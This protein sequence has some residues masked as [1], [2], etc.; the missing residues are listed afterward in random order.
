[1]CILGLSDSYAI[2]VAERTGL[3]KDLISRAR[4]ILDCLKNNRPI[5]TLPQFKAKLQSSRNLSRLN[6]PK[7]D[8]VCEN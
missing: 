5:D 7:P 1:M 4:E 3:D 8:L 2:D 6:I